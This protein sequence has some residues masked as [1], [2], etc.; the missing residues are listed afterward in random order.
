MSTY[1]AMMITTITHWVLAK[2][3]ITA[4]YFFVQLY[5]PDLARRLL[6]TVYVL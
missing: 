5:I 3:D 6:D 4:T 2:Q 1:K